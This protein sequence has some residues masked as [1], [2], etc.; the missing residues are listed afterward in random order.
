MLNTISNILNEITQ[1]G[2]MP[3]LTAVL[4]GL[5]VIL[6]PCQL[7]I[8]IS[9][10]TYLGKDITSKK[11]SRMKGIVYVIGRTLTYT[12][13]GWILMYALNKG[14]KIVWVQNLLSKSEMAIPF[15]MGAAG[16]Y[17]IIR[18]L[19][20]HHHGDQCHNS[21]KTIRRTGP[22]GAFILG[23]SLALAFCPE[24]AIFYFGILIPLS[25]KAS[26]GYALPFIFALS[27]G[28]PVLILSFLIN[29]VI[30]KAKHIER[31]IEKIKFWQNIIT[32][33][34]FLILAIA[35]FL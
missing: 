21:G 11:E 33:C 35:M 16:L 32:G 1:S 34:I 20:H 29:F 12:L 9:A 7:A 31:R 14:M 26:I 2:T 27:A 17:F 8:N 19:I 30:R 15:L 5:L 4:I 18:A 22:L 23:M 24:S 13:L 3:V 10:L 28:I 6:N 25:V